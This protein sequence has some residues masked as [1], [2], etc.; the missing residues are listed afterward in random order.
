MEETIKE[1]KEKGIT[2]ADIKTLHTHS[3]S[4]VGV[5]R[6][7]AQRRLF[8]EPFAYLFNKAKFLGNDFYV[9]RRVYIPNSETE[10]MVEALF[11]EIKNGDTV[12]DVGCGSGAIAVSIKLRVPQVTVFGVELDPTALEVARHNADF[13]KAKVQFVESLYVDDLGISAPEYVIADLPYGD[14]DH[15]LDTN[16]EQEI[17]HLPPVSFWH[18]AGSLA[19]YQELIASILKK[20][21]KTVLF[22]ETGKV[23]KEQVAKIIPPGLQWEYVQ[24]TPNYSFTKIHFS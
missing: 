23:E 10:Q 19:A 14:K 16:N 5:F 21:W 11:K 3:G 2:D 18:P 20:K 4:D 8:N 15:L 7:L 22:F 6:R 13:F 1:Y 9:D 24:T 17:P 12:V